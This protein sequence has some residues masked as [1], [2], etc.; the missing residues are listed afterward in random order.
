MSTEDQLRT[1]VAKIVHCEDP[2][3]LEDFLSRERRVIILEELERCF[4]R[5]V[6]QYGAIRALQR[7]VAATC[8]TNLWILA[9]NEVA[10]RFLNAAVHLGD[11]FSH[12]FNAGTATSGDLREAILLRHNLSGLR[13]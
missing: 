6:G 2:S 5:R 1:S 3:Q 12:R 13:L 9:I 11:I 8:S 7:L 4:L 10:F